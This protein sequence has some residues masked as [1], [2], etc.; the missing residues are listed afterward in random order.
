M[1]IKFKMYTLWH[2]FVTCW[3]MEMVCHYRCAVYSSTMPLLIA[4]PS[5]SVLDTRLRLIA[6]NLLRVHAFVNRDPSREY[7]VLT[8]NTTAHHK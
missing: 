2:I 8:V 4:R 7:Y 5:F 3:E 6:E 1:Q